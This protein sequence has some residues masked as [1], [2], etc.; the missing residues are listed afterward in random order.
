[1]ITQTFANDEKFSFKLV[2]VY[3]GRT[4]I[5]NLNGC[6]ATPNGEYGE[7]L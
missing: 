1:M 7:F 3:L 4:K 6:K 2:L 5:K